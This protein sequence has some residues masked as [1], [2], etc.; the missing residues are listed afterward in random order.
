M[1]K[2]VTPRQRSAQL[3]RQ[4]I[5]GMVYLAFISGV[6]T[7]V[8]EGNFFV[9]F[10]AVITGVV[11]TGT[12]ILVWATSWAIR[13]ESRRGQFSIA[14]M[15]F[16]TFLAALYLGV[17]RLIANQIDLPR[18]EEPTFLIA[19]VACVMLTVFSAP[20]LLL[21]MESLVW[22]AAWLVR[23]PWMQARIRRYRAQ[24]HDP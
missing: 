19:A 14:T 17:I 10:A 15:M 22:F 16:L 4:F 23:R 21:L 24:M 5:G 9:V 2:P 12:A 13:K 18:N 3:I 1:A 11:F 8:T 6:L 20:F 7:G